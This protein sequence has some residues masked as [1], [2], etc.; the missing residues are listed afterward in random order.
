MVHS[1][2]PPSEEMQ[3]VLPPSEEARQVRLWELQ[4]QMAPSEKR[5]EAPSEVAT[6]HHLE[7]AYADQRQRG[8]AHPEST[9]T[10]P[11]AVSETLRME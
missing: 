3:L 5:L 6:R 2:T 10:A 11:G 4:H 1:G 8:G 7:R 9:E